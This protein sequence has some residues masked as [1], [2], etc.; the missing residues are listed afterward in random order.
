MS[1]PPS[2]LAATLAVTITYSDGSAGC[3]HPES[4]Y[5]LDSDDVRGGRL[6]GDHTL[7]DILNNYVRNF[8]MLCTIDI[9][10][11]RPEYAQRLRRAICPDSPTKNSRTMPS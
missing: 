3:Y 10:L 8:L 7:D 6:G 1:N 11:S 9:Q 2:T 4:K 5:I